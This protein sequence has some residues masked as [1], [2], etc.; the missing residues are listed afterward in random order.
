MFR[1]GE[2][3]LYKINDI[4]D[5]TLICSTLGKQPHSFPA[6]PN[7]NFS[8]VGVFKTGAI[9]DDTHY[10]QKHDVS[11]KV[12]RVG[13]LLITCPINILLEK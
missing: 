5:S 8:N 11:G 3:Y 1:E 2:Y 13:K 4:I 7:L 9:A 6:M 12:I 10:I